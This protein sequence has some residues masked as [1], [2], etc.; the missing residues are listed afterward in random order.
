MLESFGR[1]LKMIGASIR[2]GWR[3]KR[4]LWPSFFSVIANFFFGTLLLVQ[5]IGFFQS[6]PGASAAPQHIAKQSHLLL[7]HIQ[8]GNWAQAGGLNGAFDQ[9]GFGSQIFSGNNECAWIAFLIVALWWLTNRFLEG[10]TTALVYSHLTEGPG[11]GKFSIACRAVLS[12]ME[13]IF[14]LGAATFIAKTI[15]G[16]L[17]G[18]KGA[19]VFGFGL[20]FLA[21]LVQVFWTLAGHLILPA[22]VIEGA[23][24]WGALK[25]ADKMA[26]G[27]LL[28]IGFGEVGVDALFA[29][30]S[31]LMGGLG[32]TAFYLAFSQGMLLTPLFGIAACLWALSV[33]LITAISIYIRA[34]FYTCLYVWAIEAEA[35]TEMERRHVRPPAPLAAALA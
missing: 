12:S 9:G 32:V 4:L 11:S 19:G 14:W 7:R 13:A 34:A 8:S 5:G 20:G 24:F 29:G 26:S 30:I 3:D 35:V 27:N 2:M 10:V 17:R 15:A 1:G 6:N 16:W 31:W 25:R 33:I 18:K 21:N 23:T 28:T 22:I